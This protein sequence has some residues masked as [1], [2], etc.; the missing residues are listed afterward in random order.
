MKKL[1]LLRHAHSINSLPD[2]NRELSVVGIEKC[3]DISVILSS[4]A[5]NINYILS[6]SSVRTSQT[7]EYSLPDKK[8]NYSDDCYNAT[9]EELLLKLQEISN[10]Y[11]F[12]LL[13]SHNPA[14]SELVSILSGEALSFSP[15][16]LALFDCDIEFWDELGFLN[17]KL[18]KFW[19]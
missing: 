16:S 6:S 12:I 10:K 19:Q 13:V 7:I 8:V 1:F 11:D 4:Y 5:D 17:T 2:F 14:I 9:A 18:I 15:G 3:K